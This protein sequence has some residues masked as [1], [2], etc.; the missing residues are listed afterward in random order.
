MAETPAK[1]EPLKPPSSFTL[2]LKLPT[3]LRFQ[4]LKYS[5][6]SSAFGRLRILYD[7][8]EKVLLCRRAQHLSGPSLPPLPKLK[9]FQGCRIS[10]G[11]QRIAQYLLETTSRWFTILRG[12]L[13]SSRW[14]HNS[15]PPRGSAF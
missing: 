5:L 2:F 8:S 7:I 10:F 15:L 14:K 12:P 9:F 3:E 1:L 11:L 6:P 4:I 13:D